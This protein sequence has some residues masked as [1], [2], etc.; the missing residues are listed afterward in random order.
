MAALETRGCWAFCKETPANHTAMADFRGLG[1]FLA[2]LGASIWLPNPERERGR[3]SVIGKAQDAACSSPVPVP[4]LC[5]RLQI[6][7]VSRRGALRFFQRGKGQGWRFGDDVCAVNCA[8]KMES[9]PPAS[10]AE[11]MVGRMQ[12]ACRPAANLPKGRGI[13][14]QVRVR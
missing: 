3:E 11:R 13:C 7:L 9:A 8:Y 12:A 1:P 14:K 10:E 2:S 4:C 6:R 5:A